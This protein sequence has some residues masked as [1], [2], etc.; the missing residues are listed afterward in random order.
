[1]PNERTQSIHVL[2]NTIPFALTLLALGWLIFPTVQGIVS[3]WFKFDESY[4]HGL[5]LLAVSL[6]LTGRTCLRYRVRPGFYPLWLIPFLLALIGYGLGDILRI[7]A[8]QQIVVGGVRFDIS[9]CL[10]AFLYLPCRC[11]IFFPGHFRS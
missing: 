1:M 7:Q 3:R 2:R 4:S 9:L 8:V 11:G 6:F 10:L 5:L